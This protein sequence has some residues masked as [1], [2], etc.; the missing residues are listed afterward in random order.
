[1]ALQFCFVFFW[2]RDEAAGDGN[3]WAQDWEGL[4]GQKDGRLTD[5]DGGCSC[6]CWLLGRGSILRGGGALLQHPLAPDL[7][8]TS[9]TKVIIIGL[10]ASGWSSISC[11]ISCF[12]WPCV[13]SWGQACVPISDPVHYTTCLSEIANTSVSFLGCHQQPRKSAEGP[14]PLN[15]GENMEELHLTAQCIFINCRYN[16]I[17]HT[18][19]MYLSCDSSPCYL[20]HYDFDI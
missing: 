7:F 14:W 11:S 4:A 8:P 17:E 19:S 20:C 15:C 13:V 1:M 2:I 9:A 3:K 6:C 12:L 5:G 18:P 16:A 10:T